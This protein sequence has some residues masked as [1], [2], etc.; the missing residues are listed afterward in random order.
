MVSY[1]YFMDGIL[2]IITALG[3]GF[4]AAGV[5]NVA[6]GLV[7]TALGFI[8][9]PFLYYAWCFIQSKLISAVIDYL[10]TLAGSEPLS[11]QLIGL[12]AWIYNVL[13]LSTVLAIILYACGIKLILKVMFK[14]I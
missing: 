11:L 10:T 6:L 7:V 3:L 13:N 8:I 5:F 4:S 12:S 1:C 2:W 9:C 14:A